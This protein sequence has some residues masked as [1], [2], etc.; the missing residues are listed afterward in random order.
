VRV[1]VLVVDVVVDEIVVVVV[2]VLEVVVRVDVVA[3]VQTSHK[4]GHRGLKRRSPSGPSQ[5]ISSFPHPCASGDPLH[6]SVVV[7]VVLL[8]VVVVVIVVV[9]MI[10]QSSVADPA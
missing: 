10:A 8:V 1:L 7:V 4:A 2:L 6:V 5:T 9:V 3:V